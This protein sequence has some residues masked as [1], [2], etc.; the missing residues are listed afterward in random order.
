MAKFTCMWRHYDLR[1]CL[2]SWCG[3][4][5]L[6]RHPSEVEWL[7]WCCLNRLIRHPGKTDYMILVRGYFVGPLQAV[8]LGNSVVTQVESTR[9]LGVEIDS[10]LKWN[11]HVKEL[12][13]SFSQKLNLHRSCISYQL[14]RDDSWFLFQSNFFRGKSLFDELEKIRTYMYM[15]QRSSMAWIGTHPAIRS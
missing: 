4:C 14:Q 6:E 9:C 15:P 3:C 11:V 12:V 2:F 7:A 8:S 10:G 5:C 13:K 1:G